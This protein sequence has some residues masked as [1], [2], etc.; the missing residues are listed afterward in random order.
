MRT[1]TK[2]ILSEF[3]PVHFGTGKENYDFSAGFL[4]SDTLTSALAAVRAQF[5]H[6]QDVKTFLSSFRLTSAFPYHG[7]QYF[8]PKPIGNL[9]V[10]IEGQDS[11]FYKKQLK[12]IR[13]VEESLW[14]RLIRGESLVIHPSQL[15]GNVL[16]TLGQST[17]GMQKSAVQQRV[18]LSNDVSEDGDP[19]FFDWTFFNKNSGLYCL[20]D[21]TGVVLEEVLK[22]FEVLGESGIG[23]DKNI[24]GGTFNT[25][26]APF[27]LAHMENPTGQML[28]SLYIPTLEE[29]NQLKLGN[30]CYE[31]VKRGGFMA[32]SS[33]EKLRHLRKKNIYAFG[34]GSHFPVTCSLEGQIV[35]LAPEWNEVEMHPVW[36][37]GQPITIP[38]KHLYE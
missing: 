14:K 7:D 9:D 24:G 30:A 3:S 38:I 33:V 12:K 36:R 28:L 37:S 17:A 6:V 35:D 34:V 15:N 26:V 19:F 2:I 23:T 29:V 21:A 8:L 22:W 27:E 5:G 16:S 31:L 13:F 20:T 25:S 1:Y 11:A 32:G 10:A 4:H 18:R